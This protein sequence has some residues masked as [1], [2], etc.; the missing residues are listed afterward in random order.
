LKSIKEG[1]FSLLGKDPRHEMTEFRQL[2]FYEDPVTHKV[3]VLD[4]EFKT[5][6]AVKKG[7][8][9][10]PQWRESSWYVGYNSVTEKDFKKRILDLKNEDCRFPEM[11]YP[12]EVFGEA[13]TPP[14]KNRRQKI[15][16]F[17][18]G[19]EEEDPTDGEEDDESI[20]LAGGSQEEE[21]VK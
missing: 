16:A 3:M 21:E 10:E 19:E 14:I 13:K 4:G 20:A 15:I 7:M 12:F 1:T 2:S 5:G 9:F 8:T 17:S 11:E 6:I 18:D